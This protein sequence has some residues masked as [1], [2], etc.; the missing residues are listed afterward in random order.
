MRSTASQGL[1]ALCELDLAHLGGEV[2]NR[3]VRQDSNRIYF[4]DS[5]SLLSTDAVARIFRWKRSAWRTVDTRGARLR[6]RVRTAHVG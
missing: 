4:V 2:I 3:V 5:H 6:L 1:R